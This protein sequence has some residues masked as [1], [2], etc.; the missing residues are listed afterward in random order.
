VR[1]GGD[2][3]VIRRTRADGKPN[4]LPVHLTAAYFKQR[5]FVR[6]AKRGE[7]LKTIDKWLAQAESAPTYEDQ[8]YALK[9]VMDAANH[10]L[11]KHGD[12]VDGRVGK[13]RSVKNRRS[14]VDLLE[15]GASMA[16]RGPAAADGESGLKKA[17]SAEG[18]GESQLEVASGLLDAV[19]DGSGITGDYSDRNAALGD[20]AASKDGQ[21]TAMSAESSAGVN[22][23][24]FDGLDAGSNLALGGFAI[25]GGFKDLGDEDNDAF[26]D[27]EA[28]ARALAG[29]GQM[30]HGGYKGAKAVG[31][32][33]AG[34]DGASDA[35]KTE[36]GQVGDVG[37]GFADGLGAIADTLT[38]IKGWRD[39]QKQGREQGGLTA[40]EKRER[41]LDAAAGGL[42]AT[43]KATKTALDITK[44]ATEA[45]AG[46]AMA[47][48]ATAAGAVGLVVSVIETVRGGLQIYEAWQTTQ[49]IEAAEHAQNLLI[50]E[51]MA[52]LEEAKAA[53]AAL[54]KS[55]E[56]EVTDSEFAELIDA[57]T[58]LD[59]EYRALVATQAKY[60][61]AM[62]GMKKLQARQA[63]AGAFK[64]AKGTVG[65][66][67]GA[68]LL[69]TEFYEPVELHEG[70]SAYYDCTMGHALVSTSARDA[71][72]LWVTA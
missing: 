19:A 5:T 55:P 36:F 14:P 38:S 64:A 59:T 28:G 48:L 24:T 39:A 54:V 1:V 23:T 37:A 6:G 67:S 42:S 62:D 68:L 22:S 47:G 53:T 20:V 61:P 8:Q 57:W 49:N 43:Q 52:Q 11:E 33:A 58:R 32:L 71:E 13:G 41:N 9:Q 72:V 46:H 3:D 26:D 40:K 29:G 30:I 18:S 65:V 69:Y 51:T 35:T 7:S 60:Q 31:I 21:G 15:T 27:A 63:E 16:Y 44:V 45:G 4:K 12:D 50:A 70:D 17:S 25:R 34:G 56:F 2:P 10:W 66:V